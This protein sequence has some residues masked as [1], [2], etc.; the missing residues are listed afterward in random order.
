MELSK[1]AVEEFKTIYREEFGEEISDQ[2][3]QELG[4]NLLAL[5]AIIY[6]PLP[7]AGQ[8][9]RKEENPKHPEPV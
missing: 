5:L 7:N 2:E 3:A 9:N 6:R 4:Q 8:Q 1:E